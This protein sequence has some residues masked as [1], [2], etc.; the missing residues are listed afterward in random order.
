MLRPEKDLNLA[1]GENSWLIGSNGQRYG[2][3]SNV[4]SL[5]IMLV[6]LSFGGGHSIYIFGV[7]IN[8]SDMPQGMTSGV[9]LHNHV[10][11]MK[12][13]QSYR[14]CLAKLHVGN[15]T[16]SCTKQHLVIY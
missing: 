9:W 6:Y 11:Q 5:L 7:G 12:P 2:M 13:Y 8:F 1:F 10:N 14:N 16:A 15:T 3:E 4:M